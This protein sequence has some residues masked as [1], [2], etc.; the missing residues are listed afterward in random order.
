MESGH[1]RRDGEGKSNEQGGYALSRS[2]SVMAIYRQLD[3]SDLTSST[4]GSL[5]DLF[6]NAS[7]EP[8]ENA[9]GVN[10]LFPLPLWANCPLEIRR[11]T[12]MQKKSVKAVLVVVSVL[13]VC[14]VSMF[15]QVSQ[16][17]ATQ[18]SS[19]GS[20][21]SNNVPDQDIEM[22]RADL[23]AQRKQITAQNMTLTAD[24]AT[25][26]W[27]IFDQ[28]RQEAIKPNDERWAVIKDYAA[29]YGTM[30]DAQAEDY[31][32]RSTAVDQQL[33]ALRMKYVPVFE[34][35]ISAKKTALWYQIDRRVDL[36][37][38]LQLSSQIPMVDASK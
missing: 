35:V 26:F 8:R 33:L 28:Y 11:E 21:Q 38:N 27:P 19:G 22:L 20:A 4:S 34:K 24:E 37:I 30:T 3:R 18:D 25:K 14:N 9:A 15:A 17:P 10:I 29:N 7:V 31:I 23:R 16:K 2:M 5:K 12:T 6:Q 13:F 36:L 32:K 1:G